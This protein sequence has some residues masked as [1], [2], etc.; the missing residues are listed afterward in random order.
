M[1]SG[2]YDNDADV[3]LYCLNL[4]PNVLYRDNG[5]GTFIEVTAAARA[6]DPRNSA[7]AAFVDYDADGRLDLFV[8]NYVEWTPEMNRAF[9]CNNRWGD[10]DFCSPNVYNAPAPDTLYHNNGDGTFRDVSETAGIHAV[11]GN[12]M[13]VA[14]GRQ[15]QPLPALPGVRAPVDGVRFSDGASHDCVPRRGGPRRDGQTEYLA[16]VRAALA[17]TRRLGSPAPD[18]YG[19][20]CRPATRLGPSCLL[21][22]TSLYDPRSCLPSGLLLPLP[23]APCHHRQRLLELS[24]QPQL[25]CSRFV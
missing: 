3:D 8:V 9:S 2:D 22:Q 4:G 12:G 23:G 20:T 18:R 11:Y 15:C 19:P 5:D 10:P 14:T 21:A 24:I 17:P 25:L 7:S 1:D 16:P 13:G 6:G